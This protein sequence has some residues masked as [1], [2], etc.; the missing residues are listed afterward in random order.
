MGSVR[1]GGVANSED[2]DAGGTHLAAKL[3]PKHLQQTS[4]L[5][6]LLLHCPQPPILRF[7]HLI[8]Q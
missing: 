7:P 8:L 3:P 1:R 2:K 6:V 4:E 5:L